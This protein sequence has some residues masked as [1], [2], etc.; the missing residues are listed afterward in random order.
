MVT[1]R[2]KWRAQLTLRTKLGIFVC[3]NA[4][5]GLLIVT[6]G[7]SYF[8]V[9][10]EYRERGNQALQIAE[11]VANMPE[12]VAAFADPQP[13]RIIQPLAEKI[14]RETGAQ[15]VVVGNMRLIRYSHPNPKEIGKHMVG[16]DDALVLSGHPSITEAVGTLGLSI[17]GKA[18]IF[19]GQHR[20]I[21]VVSVGFLVDDIWRQTTK[22]LVKVLG[23]SG[24]AF[25]L[26][27]VG[28]HL[29]S[30]HVKRS[31]FGMEPHEIAYLVQ[32]QASIL[33]SIAEGILAV[34]QEGRI[35][36]CNS[37]AQKLLGLTGG[38]ALGRHMS[39]VIHHP[40]ICALLE[41][42]PDRVGI[43]MIVGTTMVIAERVPVQLNNTPIGALVTFRDSMELERMQKRLA[44]I[45]QYAEAL[46]S[47]RH[48]FMNRLHTISGLIQ[49]QEYNLA[50]EL[51]DEISREHNHLITYFAN[52]IRDP[53]VLALIIGK[54]H[55]ARELGIKL[56]V[57]P[58][59]S[60]S[61]SCPH[62]EVM[63]TVLGNAIE[64]A[65]EA[66][67]Q[68]KSSERDPVVNVFLSDADSRV[69][70]VVEDAGPGVHPALGNR[71]FEDG[72]STKGPG[73]GFGLSLC[74]RMVAQ[75]QGKISIL[76]SPRG[77]TLEVE[78]PKGEQTHAVG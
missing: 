16:G 49:L 6:F 54:L 51:I 21:G 29:L 74:Y 9:Q 25:L 47:Q 67:M 10:D 8:T 30:G 1:R 61:E 20:Q 70:V 31:I 60:L 63:V 3:L 78:L 28:A 64:N 38:H 75:A 11:T 14:R 15:F 27:L 58:E 37:Q 69:R 17:R 68:E 77:A 46:R 7:Y 35:T 48:E 36:A 40:R 62:R 56:L 5:T 55:R 66:M 76:S 57:D 12:I 32:E 45:E 65:F 41:D 34:N 26:S 22:L 24:G 50:R 23:L 33:E 19:N 2:R 59:S 52:R 53:A 13:S 72:V 39:D 73:R 43:P 42:G 71:I 4:F 18:P 44:D